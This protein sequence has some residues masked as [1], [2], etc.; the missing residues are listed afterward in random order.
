LEKVS[1]SFAFK[2]P[3]VVRG[4]LKFPGLKAPPKKK[5][6]EKERERERREKGTETEMKSSKLAQQFL[7]TLSLSLPPSLFLSLYLSESF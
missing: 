4:Q 7:P 3:P 1:P 2:K 6:G 5:A